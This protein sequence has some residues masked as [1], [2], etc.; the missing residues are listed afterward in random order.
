M[1]TQKQLEKQE[2]K[3]GSKISG[4][5]K[6]HSI[7]RL[8]DA[9]RQYLNSHAV[10]VLAC[11]EA[12][13][14]GDKI[15]PKE[16]ALQVNVWEPSN[17]VVIL[18]P[19]LKKNSDDYRWLLKFRQE[20]RARQ[21]ML[22]MALMH[23]FETQPEQFLMNGGRDKAIQKLVVNYNEGFQY[24]VELDVYRCFNSFDV[25][26]VSK[27]LALPKEVC[28]NVLSGINLNISLSESYEKILDYNP[29]ESEGLT[30]LQ[31]LA[32]MDSDWEPARQGLTEGSLVSPFVCELLLA[33]VV[34]KLPKSKGR[35]INY[36]DNFL[37][38]CKSENEVKELHVI[39]QELLIKHPAGPL[40]V[41]PYKTVFKPGEP[42]EFLGYSIESYGGE[43]SIRWSEQAEKK[44]KKQRERVYNLL[45]SSASVERKA[46]AVNRLYKKQRDL[47][48][49]FQEWQNGK[50]YFR[51]KMTNVVLEAKTHG[52]THQMLVKRL[53]DLI[54]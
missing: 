35:L 47:I 43:A 36:A 52:V 39:L 8:H 32:M 44:S 28:R 3:L 29:T 31:E 50:D 24:V 48:A 51:K 19:I 14:K 4:A 38:M 2:R 33:W 21:I 46:N 30:S 54:E 12:H 40:K 53:K 17:E 7:K 5:Y 23:R 49:G 6:K 18:H 26:G 16:L 22:K 15:L 45:L 25:S 20:N 10:K 27:H 42:F 34:E 9:I 37:F 11:K 41:K 13:R 1:Q